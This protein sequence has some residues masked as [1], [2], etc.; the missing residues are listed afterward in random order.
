M[1]IFKNR[2]FLSSIC[3][4]MAGVIAFI[5]LPKFYEDKGATVNIIRAAENI[6]AGTEI[7]EK[8][9]VSVEVGKYGLP[10]DILNDKTMIIGKIAQAD[11]AAGDFLFPQKLGNNIADEKLDRIIKEDKRL[12]TISVPSIAAGL[13]SILQVGDRVTVAVFIDKNADGYNTQSSASP[14]TVYPELKDIEVYSVVNARMQNTAEVRDQ[15]GSQNN[16]DPIPKAVTLVVTEK[17]AA[18]LIEA[19]YTGK[20]HLIF[21]K[22]GITP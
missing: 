11:I 18:R 10:D 19:E 22:R 3:I 15:Q 16:S 7:Q 2:I 14:V 17:Q 1:K 9:L 12:V 6:P 8:Q 21:E 20:L 13:S 4:V 5:L